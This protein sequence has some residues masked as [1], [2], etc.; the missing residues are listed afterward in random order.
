MAGGYFV[1]LIYKVNR[2]HSVNTVTSTNLKYLNKICF[3][4]IVC[5]KKVSTGML[6][7]YF[8]IWTYVEILMEGN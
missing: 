1:L 5:P 8:C 7:I 4:D 6:C 3:L 2:E